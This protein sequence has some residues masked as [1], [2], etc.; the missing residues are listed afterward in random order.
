M[1]VYP[2]IPANGKETVTHGQPS[3]EPSLEVVKMPGDETDN[4]N[5]K[6]MKQPESEP[7]V[8]TTIINSSFHTYIHTIGFHNWQW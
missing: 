8:V 1:F 7:K 4:S 6:E 5:V 3:L 2:T